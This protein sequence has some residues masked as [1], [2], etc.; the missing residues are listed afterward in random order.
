MKTTF[1]EKTRGQRNEDERAMEDKG[2]KESQLYTVETCRGKALGCSFA[3][4]DL[5]P[6]KEAILAVLDAWDFSEQYRKIGGPVRSHHQFKIALSACPNGCSQPQIR[7]FGVLAKI[8]PRRTK[9]TCTFCKKCEKVCL[10]NAITYTEEGPIID[11]QA[12]VACGLCSLHCPTGALQAHNFSYTILIGGK[13]GR[14]PQF[15]LELAYMADEGTVLRALKL[16]L[17]LMSNRRKGERRFGDI[18]NRIGIDRLR[19]RLHD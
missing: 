1:L 18:V 3:L 15:G 11:E 7:D 2:S 8:R 6:L 10:E 13:L 14:H 16:C 19:D 17:H 12:C 4:T 9:E 5:T